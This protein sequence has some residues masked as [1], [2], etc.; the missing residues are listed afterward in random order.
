MASGYE[1]SPDQISAFS[2]HVFDDP[3]CSRCNLNMHETSLHA[4]RDCAIADAF[5]S[6]LVDAEAHP[7]FFTSNTR[8]WIQWNLTSS[9]SLLGFTWAQLFA[10]AIHYLWCVRNQEIFD[11]HTPSDE[12]IFHRFWIVFRS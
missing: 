9:G 11:H 7:Q 2:R 8:S 3:V 6:R 10:I 5:W 4:L 12:E 1:C